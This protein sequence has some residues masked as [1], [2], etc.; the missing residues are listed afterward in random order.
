M[1]K[2]ILVLA[3]FALSISGAQAQCADGETEVTVN[4]VLDRYGSE[5][6]WTLRGPGGTPT[7]ASGGPYTD[8]TTSGARPQAPVV[9][10]VPNGGA[11]TFTGTDSYGDGWCCAYGNGGYSIS[12]NGVEVASNTVYGATA[13]SSVFL[14]TD[15]SVAGLSMESVIAQG[16]L[17]IT[18]TVINSGI[19]PING[20]TLSYTVDGG[21]PFSTT[22]SDTVEPGE[23]FE[24]SHPTPWSAE[25]GSHAIVVTVS[26]VEGDGVEANNSFT[27]SLGVA[28]QSVERTTI[29]EQFTS[30][31][32]PPCASLNVTFGP[33]L[34]NLNTNHPGSHV[35]AIKY[36][37]NWP[38]PGND[39]SYNPDGNT[40]KGYYGVEGIPDLFID[41]KPMQSAE[42]AYIE[43]QAARDAFVDLQLNYWTDG[44]M[45]SVTADV[46]PY[47]A[48]SGTHRLHIGLVEN[49]YAYAASTTS[50]DEFHYVQRKMLPNGQGN[51]LTSMTAGT[52]QS[53]T[54]NYTVAFGNPAQGNYRFWDGGM[55]DITVVA[56]VQNVSTKEVVQAALAPVLVGMQENEAANTLRVFPNP[57]NGELN[58]MFD[59]S[60]GRGNAQIEVFNT[61]GER[62]YG[63]TRALNGGAQREVLDLNSLS[64]GVYFVNIAADGF[65]A[66]RTVNITK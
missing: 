10:C 11:L 55:Q 13:T 33:T 2:S 64:N 54:Q 35:A 41:G 39:P 7:Y 20:F 46:T 6:S 18:G 17:N 23:V 65:R 8:A 29:I 1:K 3:A 43:E 26:D 27:K 53:F 66:S 45:I 4:V 49:S 12:V 58:L 63:V 31:T 34:T 9:V 37:M 61:L 50:Q 59:A 62:V 47:W 19:T 16:D 15:L 38:S 44:N 22:I 40:R 36:H 5:I 52:T 60:M 48:Y 24:F 28:S 42:A 25:L 30:S 32:C 57:T 51:V 56:F 14:G 21:D